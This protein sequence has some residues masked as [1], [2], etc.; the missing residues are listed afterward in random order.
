MIS[1]TSTSPYLIGGINMP[2]CRPYPKPTL[3]LSSVVQ[4][5][6]SSSSPPP[7][8]PNDRVEVSTPASVVQSPPDF[9]TSSTHRNTSSKC[10]ESNTAP[11]KPRWTSTSTG[12]ASNSDRSHSLPRF[13]RSPPP[14]PPSLPS[15]YVDWFA[16]L[17][18]SS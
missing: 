2:H 6:S 15:S 7:P 9:E 17:P 11:L 13:C 3:L 18:S 14:S 8:L 4:L 10:A 1:L 12:T 16:A 5:L